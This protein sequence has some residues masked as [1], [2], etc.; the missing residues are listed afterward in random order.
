MDTTKNISSWKL[1]LFFSYGFIFC[2]IISYILV[3]KI[4]DSKATIETTPA[5][6]QINELVLI[7]SALKKLKPELDEIVLEEILTYTQ[8]YAKEYNLPLT[9]VLAIMNRESGFNPLA[10]SSKGAK[11]LMQIMVKVHEDKLK[12]LKINGYQAMHIGNNIQLGC[13]I[14]REYYN[15]TKEIKKALKKYVGG[16]QAGYYTDILTWYVTINTMIL[17]KEN[18]GKGK[19]TIEQQGIQQT[20]RTVQ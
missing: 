15:Q 20:G 7:E 1:F 6:K 18:N 4:I 8:K 13:M 3:F 9:L 14:L 19:E 16:V 11:G 10:I 17:E 2:A 5:I 12:K